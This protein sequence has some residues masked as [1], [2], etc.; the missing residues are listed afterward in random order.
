MK[1][2]DLVNISERYLDLASPISPAKV[3]ELGKYLRLREGSRVIDFA[4]GY[5]EALILW[6]ER[7]GIVGTGVEVREQA[8][9]RARAKVAERGL[10]DRVEIVCAQAA[11]HPFEEQ[12]FDAATCMG[13]SFV[14]GGYRQT[15]CALRRAIHATGR[16]GI[17][18]PYW[19]RDSVPP[20]IVAQETS[21]HGEHSLVQIARAEGFDFEYVIRASQDDWDTY[22]AGNWHGLVRWIEEHP[23]HPEREAVIEH[24]HEIQDEYLGYGREYVGWAMYVL[25]PL[26]YRS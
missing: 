13:A 2:F 9:Q 19:R 17:G 16:L 18:E 22:A 12:T 6:A 24:L 7:F 26:G 3:V 11:G 15:V 23:E 21:I 14:F 1:F 20:E 5:A 8:C 4:C 10:C 25:A